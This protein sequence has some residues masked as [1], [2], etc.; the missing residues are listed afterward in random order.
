VDAWR[1]GSAEVP[2]YDA[3][4]LYLENGLEALNRQIDIYKRELSGFAAD[5][6]ALVELGAGYGSII[7]RLAASK[8]F[9]GKPLFAAEFTAAGAKSMVRL[10]DNAGIKLVIGRC[11][12]GEAVLE[13]FEIPPNALI[14]TSYAVHYVPQLQEKFMQLFLRFRP[15]AVVNFEPVLEHQDH[16]LLGLMCQKYIALNDYNRNLLTVL[17]QA[18]QAGKIE[19]VREVKSRFGINPFLPFSVLAWRARSG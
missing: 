3:G 1:L 2:C 17:E 15:R 4:S 8:E 6:S 18:T 14:F 13:G 7:L 12:F 10:A 19:I 5:C 11:D 16:S 9:Q